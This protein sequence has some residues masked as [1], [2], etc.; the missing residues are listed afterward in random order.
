MEEKQGLKV[1]GSFVGVLCKEDGTVTTTRKDNMILNC[2]YDFIADAIGKTSG[3]PDTMN[4]IAVGT[5]DER[6]YASQNRLSGHLLT[7]EATYQHTEGTKTFSISTKFEKGEATGALQEA[8]VRNDAGLLDRVV[9]P[10]VNK[11]ANDTYEVT[12]TFTMS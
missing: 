3:R 10:V 1:H 7:K 8:C 4:K 11:G 12:F 6:V 5:R 9:F 2:G